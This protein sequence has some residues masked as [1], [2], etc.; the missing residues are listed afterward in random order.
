MRGS[1]WILKFVAAFTALTAMPMS[2]SAQTEAEGRLQITLLKA[3]QDSGSGSLFY[4][5][6][7][8]G[9]GVSGIKI[10]GFWRTRI[11]LIGTALNLRS[12]A[13]IIGAYTPVDDG[14]ATVGPA[15]TARLENPK[16]V[17]LE[18]QGVNMIRRFTLNLAG[19]TIKNLGW[20]PSPDS[21]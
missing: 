20:Q 18:I 12:A 15:R 19:M 9:L 7:K 10:R 11:D 6:Q 13:D 17:V 8:Y 2:A 4:Q 3:G 21:N 16:G 1:F 5:T 14:A